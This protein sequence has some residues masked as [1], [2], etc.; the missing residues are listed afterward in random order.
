MRAP[1]EVI[2]SA[3]QAGGGPGTG[4]DHVAITQAAEEQLNQ[5][6]ALIQYR[7]WGWVDEATRTYG[8]LKLVLLLLTKEEGAGLAFADFA[9]GLD[10]PCPAALRLD[11]CVEGAAGLAGRLGP[12]VFTLSGPGDL[13]HLATLQ[14]GNLRAP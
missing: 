9:R 2:L 8:G 6:Y 1:A 3:A 10:H 5:A 4:R 12:Y 11:E 14:A 7:E 13:E